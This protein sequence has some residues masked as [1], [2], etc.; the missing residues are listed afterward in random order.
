MALIIF[1]IVLCLIFVTLSGI[2]FYWLFGGEWGYKQAVPTK[3][4]GVEPAPVPWH[5]TL[6]VALG[7]LG[8]ALFYLY[9]ADLTSL[10][11]PSWIGNYGK[12]IVP[13]IFTIRAIGEFNYVGFFKKVKDT[14][15]AKADTR[16]FAPLCLGIGIVGFGVAVLVG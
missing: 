9:L 1:C 8:M 6:V 16:L 3:E 2:H 13:S 5:M 12:W 11:I 14:D 4:K 7:L 15:F 10:Y